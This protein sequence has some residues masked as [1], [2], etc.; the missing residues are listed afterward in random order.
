MDFSFPLGQF[1]GLFCGFIWALNVLIMR[2]QIAAVPPALLNSIRCGAAA[3]LTWMMLPFGPPLTTLLEVPLDEWG[4]LLG[5]V[6]VTIGI[7]DTLYLTAIKYIGVPR[8]LALSGIFPLP[9]I[10]FEWLLL[11]RPFSWGFILGCVFVVSGVICLAARTSPEPKGPEKRTERLHLGAFLAL[12]AALIW[13]LGTV[14]TKPAIAHLTPIQA[15]SIRLP[16][17][18]LILYVP[19][20]WNKNAPRLHQLDRYTL[21]IVSLSGILGMGLGSMTYLYAVKLIGPAESNT[22]AS[23]SPVFGL[24]MALI[25][26]KEKIIFR[27]ALGVLLCVVGVWLVL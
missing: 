11:G 22:L 7:G 19:M 16:L 1:F 9:T 2:P 4:L 25:F 27:L 5:S 17:V 15:N 26:F 13:G 8:A 23:T 20:L 24:L 18:A 12:A 6:L 10:F 3:V 21:F 14:M